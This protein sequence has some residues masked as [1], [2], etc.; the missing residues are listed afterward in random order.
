MKPKACKSQSDIDNKNE[1]DQQI[2]QRR[3]LKNELTQKKYYNI[4]SK[5]SRVRARNLIENKITLTA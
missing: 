1:S 3:E 2:Y 5:L 4:K